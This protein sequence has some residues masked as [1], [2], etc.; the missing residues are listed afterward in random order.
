MSARHEEL[1]RKMFGTS[2]GGD[3]GQL[4]D[5]SQGKNSS[6]KFQVINCFN[7]FVTIIT[8]K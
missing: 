4:T 5:G 2:G 3:V 8:S 6:F 1:K 7:A